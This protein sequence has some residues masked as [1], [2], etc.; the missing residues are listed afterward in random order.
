MKCG[1]CINRRVLT[2]RLGLTKMKDLCQ[3]H[4][5]WWCLSVLSD[6]SIIFVMSEDFHKGRTHW[7]QRLG[8][9]IILNQFYL[10]YFQDGYNPSYPPCT[11]H[12]CMFSV[13]GSFICQRQGAWHLWHPTLWEMQLG[14]LWGGD[15]ITA[16]SWCLYHHQRKA[17]AL[18]LWRSKTRIGLILHL[19][20]PAPLAV[21]A[22]CLPQPAHFSLG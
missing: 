1:L 16:L 13:L 7:N 17:F 15:P 9:V 21:A 20:S 8:F 3:T 5:W 11:K 14:I 2:S 19:Q 10:F 22:W 18:K 4:H 6:L 12:F